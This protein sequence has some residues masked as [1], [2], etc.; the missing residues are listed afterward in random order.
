MHKYTLTTFILTILLNSKIGESRTIPADIITPKTNNDGLEFIIL[1]NNDMHARFEE[2]GKDSIECSP[3]DRAANQCYGGFARTATVI[4]DFRAKA[5]APGGTPVVYLNAGDTFSGT[6]WHTVFKENITTAFLNALEPEAMALGNHEFDEGVIGLLPLIEHAKFP[7]LAANLNLSKTPELAAE[8]NLVNST[9]ITINGTRVGIV[10]YL[11]PDTKFL[12]RHNDV[13]YIPE[14]EGINL[15]TAKLRAEGINIIIALGHSG[16]ETDKDIAL[17][18]PDVDVVVGGHSNTF[19]YTGTPPDS[20]VPKGLYPVIIRQP[21]GKEV[22]VVQAYAF[23]KYMG[24]LKLKF[25]SNGDLIQH[26][27]NPIL[28]DHTIPQDQDILDLLEKYRPGITEAMNSVLGVSKVKLDGSRP[29]CRKKE[30]NFGNMITD[31]MIYV[32]VKELENTPHQYWTDAAISFIQSGGIRES[33]EKKTDTQITKNDLLSVLPFS[34][35]LYVAKVPGNLIRATLEHSAKRYDK[36]QSTGGFLQMSGVRVSYDMA[37]PLGER[38]LKVQVLCADCDIPHYSDLDDTK[39]YKV[40]LSDFLLNG[41]DGHTFS[42]SPNPINEAEDLNMTDADAVA[43][44]IKA[45][46]PVNPAIEGRILI[47]NPKIFF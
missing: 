39:V 21:S 28:L 36:R 13:E 30:C 24:N 32:R 37:R 47:K 40:V 41:G 23:T 46:S 9:I 38:V 33:I 19:L 31:A 43:E 3:E 8:A 1:H 44:Y 26:S 34:N 18:C 6:T 2:T 14:V 11:T 22:P 35:R 42:N 7:V 29:A 17:R 27:G 12:N 45:R 25:D 10:G 20:D 16:F 15:E 4:K 5:K